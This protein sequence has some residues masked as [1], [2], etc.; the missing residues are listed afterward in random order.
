MVFLSI[1]SNYIANSILGEAAAAGNIAEESS[2][3]EDVLSTTLVTLSLATASLG[4]VLMFLGKFKCADAVSYLPLPVVGG[5]LAFIGY[6]CVIAG[7]GLCISENMVDGDFLSNMELLL[8][9]QNI[10]LALAGMVS[11][12]VMM[13]VA[14]NATHDAVLPCTMVVI[15]G[16]FYM[17]LYVN[18]YNL[19]MCFQIFS[20]IYYI[21]VS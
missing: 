8:D 19:K 14:R 16:I 17:I 12:F 1:M 6:F 13:I 15:P 21:F 5:Y 11:G 9:E 2:I 18:S 10:M 7:I 4:V 3:V 20:L